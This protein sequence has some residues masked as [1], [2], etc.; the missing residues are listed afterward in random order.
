MTNNEKKNKPEYNARAF[1]QF[2]DSTCFFRGVVKTALLV[3]ATIM[4]Y[5]IFLFSAGEKNGA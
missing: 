5:V 1:L 2:Y 3:A 4:L